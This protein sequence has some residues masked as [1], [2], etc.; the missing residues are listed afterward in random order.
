[1]KNIKQFQNNICRDQHQNEQVDKMIEAVKSS[2]DSLT[3]L[4]SGVLSSFF[5]TL[6][7]L[8]LE[9]TIKHT[10]PR[11]LIIVACFGVIWFV[12]GKWVVPFFNKMIV[13]RKST[14]IDELSKQEVVNFFNTSITLS[15]IEISDAIN[16]MKDEKQE[17]TCR[18]INEVIIVTEYVKCINYIVEHVKKQHIRTLPERTDKL[19]GNYINQYVL[20]LVYKILFESGKEI[21]KYLDRIAVENESI[22]LIKH[23]L[24]EALN[25]FDTHRLSF[26]INELLFEDNDI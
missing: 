8:F 3:V 11:V 24:N 17:K 7:A 1:M 20:T 26:G 12:G 2:N 14:S 6:I 5:S 15:A 13:Q 21:D 23:D 16:I 19:M 9:D 4:F 22:S 18:K 25:S 10:V